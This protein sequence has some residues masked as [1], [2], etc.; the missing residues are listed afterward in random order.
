MHIR[1]WAGSAIGK[2]GCEGAFRN[3]PIHPDDRPLLAMRWNNKISIDKCLLFRLR[4]AP[5]IFAALADALQWII[6]QKGV[7]YTFHY[8]DDL[9]QWAGRVLSNIVTTWQ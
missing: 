4:S 2:D 3:I 9:S 5:T 1:L 7:N 6:Q 8:V